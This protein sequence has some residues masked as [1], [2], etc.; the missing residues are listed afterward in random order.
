MSWLGQAVR[1]ERVDFANTYI[2]AGA[3]LVNKHHETLKTLMRYRQ[4][5]D[6]KIIVKN[7][8]VNQSGQTIVGNVMGSGSKQKK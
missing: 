6:Q 8:N 7:V 5:G 3:K 4:G 1:S 2:N